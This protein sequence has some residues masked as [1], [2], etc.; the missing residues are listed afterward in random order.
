VRAVPVQDSWDP[1]SV[2]YIRSRPDIYEC[3]LYTTS[4]RGP[5]Y[6]FLCTMKTIDDKNKWIRA[7]VAVIMQTDAA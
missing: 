7:G 6:V 1:Q 2:G 4:F 5:T 3:P